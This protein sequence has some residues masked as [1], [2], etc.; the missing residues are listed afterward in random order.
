MVMPYNI[1]QLTDRTNVY[2]K[3]VTEDVLVQVDD[4][5]FSMKIFVLY[6]SEK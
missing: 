3:D 2:P 4:M 1:I 5:I 6:M